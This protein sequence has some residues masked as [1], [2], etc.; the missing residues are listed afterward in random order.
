M[1]SRKPSGRKKRLI[2]AARQTRWA[3]F[4]VIPK[5]F[6]TGRKVHPSSITK[7]KR[8]WRRSS[9]QKG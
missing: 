5:K 7:I 8:R 3:P 6:G 2:S 4:W 1:S 9:I